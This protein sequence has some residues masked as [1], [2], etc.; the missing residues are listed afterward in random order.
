MYLL[1][2]GIILRLSRDIQQLFFVFLDL[3]LETHV[4]LTDHSLKFQQLG[5]KTTTGSE[6]LLKLREI[7][8]IDKLPSH[9]LVV[10]GLL[11]LKQLFGVAESLLQLS[12]VDFLLAQLVL[13]FLDLLFGA[14]RKG[15]LWT[16][17]QTKRVSVTSDRFAHADVS[18][19]LGLTVAP[20]CPLSSLICL[21]R[22][23]ILALACSL[24]LV[25]RASSS[26]F[27]LCK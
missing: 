27:S 22:E 1:Q 11:L 8:K 12:V 9:L 6:V 19:S 21:L 13:Q 4:L 5:N 26:S 14:S 18:A 16:L 24:S 20:P 23:A 15:A 7:R 17:L 2:F 10:G 25:K 3:L